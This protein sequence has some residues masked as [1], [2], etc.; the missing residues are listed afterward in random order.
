[1]NQVNTDEAAAELREKYRELI[2]ERPMRIR[3]AAAAL[4]VSEGQLLASRVGENVIR[5]KSEAQAILE[6][7]E[8]LG[9]V[10]ALTRNENCVN[11]RKGVYKNYNFSQH[12]PMVVGT[13]VGADIDLRLF[14]NHWNFCFAVT[15]L[16]QD[17]TMRSLQFF[18]KSGTA[19]HKIYMT[20]ES[21]LDEYEKLVERFA[22]D[23]QP[24][25]IEVEAYDPPAAP[26]SDGE[27]DWQEFRAA[28]EAMRDTHDFFPLLRKYKVD[29]QQA[30]RNVGDDIAYPVSNDASKRLLEAA[31]DKNCEIMVFVGNRGCIGIHTGPVQ[32]LVEMEGWYNVLDPDFNLHLKTTSIANT[33]VTRKPTETGHVTAVEVFDAEGELIVTFFGKRKPGIPELELWREIVAELPRE[34]VSA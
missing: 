19:V 7:M 30:F 8:P 20:D 10:M 33:W 12:G 29:R 9:K 5:L 18:D 26:P 2:E 21:N 3:N 31:R 15:D 1:M 16:V 13:F 32:K 27:V 11:E 28:W 25:W 17:R 6:Q 24:R 22:A 14:M 4:G 34:E 23:E